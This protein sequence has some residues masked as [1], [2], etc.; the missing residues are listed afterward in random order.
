M[1]LFMVY[2]TDSAEGSA[3]RAATRPAHLE[4]LGQYIKQGRVTWAG[5]YLSPDGAKPLGSL[6]IMEGADFADVQAIMAKDPYVTQGVFGE[7]IIH[8]VRQ[9]YPGDA[10]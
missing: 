1:P 5:P 6:I 8:P 3:K 10:A 2:A 7:V 4:H 9:V